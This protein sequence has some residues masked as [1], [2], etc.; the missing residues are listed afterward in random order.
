MPARYVKYTLK[1]SVE[2]NL[3]GKLVLP[4]FQREFVWDLEK[5]KRLLSSFLCVLPVGSLLILEASDECDYLLDGQQ[6]LSSLT[7]FFS[8]LFGDVK[9]YEINHDNLYGALRNRWFL[10]LEP[11]ERE[12]DIFGWNSLK[13]SEGQIYNYEPNDVYDFLETSKVYKKDKNQWWHPAYSPKDSD[14]EF[15]SSAKRR[16]DIADNAAR[17]GLLP[18]W[19]FFEKPDNGIHEMVL[20]KISEKLKYEI[21]ASIEDGDISYYEILGHL[22]EEIQDRVDNGEDIE[23]V[24]M[25]LR[26]NWK[27][28]I[29]TCIKNCVH[30]QEIPVVSLPSEEVGRA[31][32]TF[33]AINEGGTRL[34]PF[35]L[36]VARAAKSRREKSLTQRIVELLRDRVEGVEKVF[37]HNHGDAPTS[38]SNKSFGVLDDNVPSTAF[39]DIFLNSISLYN[40]CKLTGDSSKVEHIKSNKILGLSHEQINDH[41]EICVKSI[42]KA[43]CFLTFRCGMRSINDLNYKLMILPIVFAFFDEEVFDDKKKLDQIEY[44]YWL[45]LFSGRYREYQNEKCVEDIENLKNYLNNGETSGLS[46]ENKVLNSD[47]Y[48]DLKTFL[49]D[50]EDGVNNAIRNGVLNYILSRQPRDF[51]FDYRISP[52]ELEKGKKV[53]ID[54]KEVS[55]EIHDHHIMPLAT[56]SYVGE[57]TAELRGKRDFILNSPLNRTY[58][59]AASNI[60]IGQQSISEYLPKIQEAGAFHHCIPSEDFIS[61]FPNDDNIDYYRRFLTARYEKLRGTIM[62]ELDDLSS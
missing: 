7:S 28:E 45:S 44:W 55:L 62:E 10:R 12:L 42:Q 32:A 17:N 49:Y 21:D 24:W 29:I 53:T 8:N 23:E 18:L 30:F 33:S 37:D 50:S 43:L 35:D 61:Q 38:W 27:K 2:E 9:D 59:L 25:E 5:Q 51:I 54:G 56:A 40:Y 16:E 3:K 19:D 46:D 31:V 39:K 20:R 52:W 47:G 34:D 41:V 22:S 26:T 48:S 11:K 4:N 13:F 1:E 14:G 36:I 57:S 60:A 15:L 6:R 58:I